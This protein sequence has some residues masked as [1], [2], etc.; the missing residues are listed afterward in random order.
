MSTG[1]DRPKNS[2]GN[3]P[4]S[5]SE[6]GSLRPANGRRKTIYDLARLAGASPTSVS[7]V[8]SGSWRKRRISEPLAARILKIAEDEGY[9]RNMQASALRSERSH[10]IGMLVP[11]YDNRY[12]G[13]IAERFETL[14]RARSLFPIITCTQ[15]DPKLELEAARAMIAH[16]V[17]C[18]VSCGA[19]DPD[20]ITR[21]C[22]ASGVRSLNLDL[23]GTLAPS[24][25]SDNSGGAR[26]L[27]A[28]LLRRLTDAGH[29]PAPLLFVG[30][31]AHDHNTV[32]RIAGF[33]AAHEESG[34]V[35][36]SELILVSGYAPEK[37]EAALSALA[38]SGRT[39]P[40]GIFVNS[41]ITLEGVVRWLKANGAYDARTAYLGCF[42]WDPLAAVLSENLLM[43]RQ[44]VPAMLA[45]LFTLIDSGETR[46][47][48]ID[49]PTRFAG[50]A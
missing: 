23:P 32:K 4:E 17:D 45:A 24:V 10:L 48:I 20:R 41:T 12:F 38:A 16:Q 49:L 19:T 39:L 2:P 31:R 9:S 8:L 43:V 40:P 11:K 47:E 30:G 33:R 5:E 28:A 50:E 22:E 29:P 1:G 7:A 21:I 15:R 26:A 27:T 25:I 14:A 3:S 42:D 13:A 35:V 18:I 37:A 6:S 44:D 46:A 36:P 34:L